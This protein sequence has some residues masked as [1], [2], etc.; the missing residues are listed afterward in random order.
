MRFQSRMLLFD[1]VLIAFFIVA[2]FI[3][4]DI[5]FFILDY[6]IAALLAIDLA[7]RAWAFGDVRRWLR[8]PIVWAD[9]AVLASLVAPVLAANLGFL[10]IMRIYSL[11]QGENLWRIAGSGRWAD[12]NV[13]CPSSEHLAQLAA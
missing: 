6:A 12:T 5:T 2:P 10:R 11:V 8:R 3:E 1:V 4:R 13:Q 9:I 7:L